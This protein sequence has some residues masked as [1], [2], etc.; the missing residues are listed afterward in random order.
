LKPLFFP[1]LSGL[2]KLITLFDRDAGIPMF[3]LQNRV[4][5]ILQERLNR[6]VNKKFN[7]NLLWLLK[8]SKKIGKKK[9][10]R[11]IGKIIYNI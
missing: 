9:Y 5:D 7:E 3:W 11:S 1:I 4:G 10:L 2:T 6:N 8:K